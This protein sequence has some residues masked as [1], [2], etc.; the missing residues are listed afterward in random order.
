[1]LN[2]II[3]QYTDILRYKFFYSII[4]LH[5]YKNLSPWLQWGM[6]TV[7][8]ISLTVPNHHP[9]R[10]VPALSC[11]YLSRMLGASS[12]CL[13]L[14]FAFVVVIVPGVAQAAPFAFVVSGYARCP[15]AFVVYVLGKGGYLVSCE[16]GG[17]VHT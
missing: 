1:M 2:L 6:G 5:T 3:L 7:V 14:A 12:S 15:L 8:V 11:S 13:S 10:W 9:H 17:G 4:Y 16:V